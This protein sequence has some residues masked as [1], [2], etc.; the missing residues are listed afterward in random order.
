[1]CNTNR[2]CPPFYLLKVSEFKK[3]QGSGSMRRA[4]DTHL[5]SSYCLVHLD[6]N[7]SCEHEQRSGKLYLLKVL[8]LGKSRGRG[9]CGMQ[10][11]HKY[12]P[13]FYL[14]KLFKY[15]KEQG[16]GYVRL[17]TK[18]YSLEPSPDLIV[19]GKSEERLR[20]KP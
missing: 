7:L 3:Q 11:N 18:P 2:K 10:H 6:Q 14:P 12:P 20:N 9:A 8:T 17:A 15:K 16:S 5:I 4:T 1:M 19:T 13:P